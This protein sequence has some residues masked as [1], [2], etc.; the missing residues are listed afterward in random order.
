M[1]FEVGCCTHYIFSNC[2]YVSHATF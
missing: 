1:V 2:M